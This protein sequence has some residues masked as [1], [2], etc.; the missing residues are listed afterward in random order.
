MPC[1]VTKDS[2]GLQNS[3]PMDGGI[4]VHMIVDDDLEDYKPSYSRSILK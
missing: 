2:L 4:L 1:R 3:M